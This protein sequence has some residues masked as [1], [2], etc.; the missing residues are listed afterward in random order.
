MMAFLRNSLFS[1]LLVLSLFANKCKAQ[2][3]TFEVEFLG[4]SAEAITAFNYA[5]NIWSNYLISDVPIK[6]VAHM[7]PLL[8]GQ[9]GITFPNGELNYA[10]APISDVWYASC[11]ANA[12]SGTDL[13]GDFADIEIYFSSLANWYYGLDENPGPTQYDF[14]SAVLHEICHGLGFLSLS[15]KSGT[16]GSFG[17]IDASAFAPLTTTFA[18]P[19]L[20][21]MPSVFDVYLENAVGTVLTSFTNP[22]TELG[23]EIISNQIFFNSLEIIIETGGTKPKIYAPGAF[24]L[25]SSLSHWD[26]DTY[27]VGND[28]EFM[29]P[30]A[31]SGHAGH[32]PG[33]L[34]LTVLE[35]IG[36]EINYDTGT[37]KLENIMVSEINIFP[38][39]IQDFLYLHR[40]VNS[41]LVI[42]IFNSTGHIIYEKIFSDVLITIPLNDLVSGMYLIKLQD[43]TGILYKNIMKL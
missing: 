12:I 19:A 5:A 11:L 15:N 39:P 25:G 41:N 22:S 32:Q 9:L 4:L 10:G 29:T 31:A 26:E 6:I 20:D 16:T 21:T 7:Q 36:W 17:L 27:P 2:S 37:V 23:T 35:E 13:N 3:A 33:I 28:N 30:Q 1:T 43:N 40:N 18:W 14:V 38:N 34:T 24:T 8:P 42:S